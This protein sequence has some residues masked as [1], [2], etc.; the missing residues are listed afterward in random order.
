[1]TL[2]PSDSPCAE[3]AKVDQPSGGANIILDLRYCLE[4]GLK[5]WCSESRNDVIDE[6]KGIMQRDCF[7]KDLFKPTNELKHIIIRCAILLK[8]KFDVEGLFPN[9]KVRLKKGGRGKFHA[10]DNSSPNVCSGILPLDR[11][12]VKLV[13]DL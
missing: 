7:R 5:R 12:A 13:D 2:F 1:M 3:D 8:E 6:V 10:A 4:E 9:Y 11:S